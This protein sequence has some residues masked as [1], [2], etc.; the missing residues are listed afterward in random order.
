MH[1]LSDCVI[2][3]V[4]VGL[5]NRLYTFSISTSIWYLLQTK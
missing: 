3:R 4:Y 2:L 5:T 1:Q